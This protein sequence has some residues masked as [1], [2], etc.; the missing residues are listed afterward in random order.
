MDE[1]YNQYEKMCNNCGF[2]K[3]LGKTGLK[4][5]SFEYSSDVKNG[6]AEEN[7]VKKLDEY[8]PGKKTAYKKRVRDR[9]LKK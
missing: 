5:C 4:L 2:Y 7:L 1:A 9:T 3:K 8:I 6:P